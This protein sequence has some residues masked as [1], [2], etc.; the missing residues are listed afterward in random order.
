[1][2]KGKQH[3]HYLTLPSSL[4]VKKART[5]I[6]LVTS[7]YRAAL[8][9]AFMILMLLV[10]GD[11]DFNSLFDFSHDPDECNNKV[12][13]LFP[14]VEPIYPGRKCTLTNI[15]TSKHIHNRYLLS[16]VLFKFTVYSLFN[17]SD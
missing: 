14:D 2:C 3:V 11:R 7:L 4:Q 10:D 12:Q 5:K 17:I 6:C 13:E 8:I 15:L 9:F 1:M 16:D